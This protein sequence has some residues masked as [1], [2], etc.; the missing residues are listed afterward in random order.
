MRERDLHKT[1][2]LEP[3]A[4]YVPLGA[5]YYVCELSLQNMCY[6]ETSVLKKCYIETSR[7]IC[8]ANQLT[9]FYMRATLV[10]HGL[11]LS[12]FATHLI[13]VLW[14]KLLRFRKNRYNSWTIISSFT[15]LAIYFIHGAFFWQYHACDICFFDEKFVFITV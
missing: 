1:G 13:Y 15:T 6:I 9:G 12:F 3:S 14:L 10:F 11:K 2:D 5:S 8:T 7:L 4:N